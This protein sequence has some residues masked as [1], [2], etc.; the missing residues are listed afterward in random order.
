M[1][2]FFTCST[3]D[4][5]KFANNYRTI[6]NA[7][8]SE[9]NK[10]KRDWIDYSINLAKRNI[11]QEPTHTFYNDVMTA[12][13]TSDAIVVDA[14][15]RSM[16]IGHQLTY[17]LLNNK[18]VLLLRDKK[19]DNKEKLFIEGS[20]AKNLNVYEYQNLKDAKTIV[21]RFFKKYQDKPK[22]RFNLVL[23]G[24]LNNYVNWASFYYKKTKTE[25]IHEAIDN[26]AE[27]DSL[28]KGFVTKGE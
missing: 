14:T 21:K 10:I 1:N 2:V 19:N 18:P 26:V 23:T 24:S 27:H 6:R 20:G 4:I 13:I 8:I 9:G 12:I 3:K 15:V 17:A 22:A 16:A 28:Y 7:I 25:I 5:D 11:P